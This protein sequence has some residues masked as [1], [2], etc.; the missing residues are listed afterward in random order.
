MMDLQ[1]GVVI[2]TGSSSG[3]GAACVTQLAEL[4]CNVVVNYASNAEGAEASSSACRAFGVE[5]EVVQ[6][7]VARDEDCRKLVAAAERRWGRLDGL[8]NNAG[9]T[10]F[11]PHDDLEGLSGQD[12]LDIYSVN[13]VGPYQMARAA[14]PLMRRGGRGSIV[15]VAS[16][17][18]IM[19]IGSSIAYAASKGAL[20]TL[21]LSLARTL[22]PEIRVNTVCPG[23][24][25]GDWLAGG[26]GAETYERTKSFLESNT[27]LRLTATAD[28]VAESI[29]YFLRGASVVTGETL[30]LDG[31]H[32]LTQMPIARR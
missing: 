18:G 23:F 3:V 1:E 25:Q 26:L 7:D 13:L 5:T 27:P 10:K 17:A 9:T 20:I 24:I 31:G 14:A 16:I 21:G 8:V 32:H 6:G 19:G 29:L 15:N 30:L 2:V 4:G 12:F 22:G 28:T 11:C